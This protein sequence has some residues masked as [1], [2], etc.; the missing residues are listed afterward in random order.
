MKNVSLTVN[1]N[2][3]YAPPTQAPAAPGFPPVKSFY[4]V[5]FSAQF[6][7]EAAAIK[8]AAELLNKVSGDAE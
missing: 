5:S 7:D 3:S 8:F 1:N 6:D 2:S 4:A